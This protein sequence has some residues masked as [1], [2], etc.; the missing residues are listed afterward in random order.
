LIDEINRAFLLRCHGEPEHPNKLTARAELGRNAI[1]SCGCVLADALNSSQANNDDERQ[2]NR[3]LNRSW[4][5]FAL[6]KT[7]QF[8]GE[9]FHVGN[10]PTGSPVVA[11]RKQWIIMPLE[12]S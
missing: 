2:H 6:Q 5:V 7:L 9:I 3:V 11:E 1:E 4:S 12:L 10:P 8:H